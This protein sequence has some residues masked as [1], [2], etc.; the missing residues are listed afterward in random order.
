[1]MTST[2]K[3]LLTTCVVIATIYLVMSP[4]GEAQL[5][6]PLNNQVRHSQLDRHTYIYTCCIY[7][8]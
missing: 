5:A 2:G 3:K 6:L 4:L 8:F 7:K 1:M